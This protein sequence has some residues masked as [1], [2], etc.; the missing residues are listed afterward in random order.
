MNDQQR[1]SCTFGKEEKE[2]KSIEEKVVDGD[3]VGLA[4][5]LHLSFMNCLYT[6][7][8]S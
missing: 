3:A 5:A 4:W 1:E 8:T 2:L 6:I 7:G